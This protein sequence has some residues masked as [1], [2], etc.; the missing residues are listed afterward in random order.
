MAKAKKKIAAKKVAKK[1][2]KKTTKPAPKAKA[3]AKAKAAT[4]AKVK[5]APKKAAAAKAMK[6]AKPVAKVAAKPAA[7]ARTADL[8]RLFTPLDNR[9]LVEKAGAAHRTPGGLYIPDSVSSE[10]RPTQGKVVAVGR[11]HIDKK[12]RLQPLDVKVGDTVMFNAFTGS[13]VRIDNN[14]FL[15]LREEEILAI[16]KD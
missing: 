2:P 11:G 6:A 5:T 14:D 12:G 10:D 16:V 4:K 13:E 3:A 8:S 9:I 1:A 7:R 15:C